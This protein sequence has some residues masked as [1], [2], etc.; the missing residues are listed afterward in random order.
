MTGQDSDRYIFFQKGNVVVM[1]CLR[2][3]E[4]IWKEGSAK[5]SKLT[6]QGKKTNLGCTQQGTERERTKDNS[7][8][9]LN[10]SLASAPWIGR[11]VRL[12]SPARQIGQHKMNE[13]GKYAVLI[14]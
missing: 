11:Y 8:A 9:K 12:H 7:R 2:W 13:M 10:R 5:K 1:T 4:Y 6:E 3:V 14:L